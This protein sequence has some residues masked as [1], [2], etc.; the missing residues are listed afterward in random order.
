M[1]IAKYTNLR[2]AFLF[3]SLARGSYWQPV[4]SRFVKKFPNTV[5][6]TGLWEGFLSHYQNAFT[7]KVV[8]KTSFCKLPFQQQGHYPIGFV[9]APILKLIRELW[10]FK[11]HVLFV[12]GFSLWTLVAFIYKKGY[13]G[14]VIVIYDGSS[15]SVDRRDSKI[16]TLWRKYIS[17]KV[18]VFITNTKAGKKYLVTYL[19]IDQNKVLVH[20]Y[21][22]PDVSIWKSQISK[23]KE[24]QDRIIS[25][26]TVG[27]L[28]KQ[29]GIRELINATKILVDHFQE[30]RWYLNIVGDGPLRYEIE[31]MIRDYN[32]ENRIRLIGHVN[33]ELLGEVLNTQDVFIFPTFEDVWGVAPLEAM[34]LGKPVLC[35]KYAGAHE[36]ITEGKDGWI[37]DPHNPK[38]LAELMRKFINNPE[39][40]YIMSANAKRKMSKY[41]PEVAVNF[42]EQVMNQVIE[43]KDDKNKIDSIA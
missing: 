22:V 25:F 21:E 4:L 38:E 6:F 12:S 42:L 20:P 24:N 3:P 18:D 23:R 1:T 10:H 11:P 31:R 39:L 41:T 8:G 14:K 36:L 17:R 15:P 26:V 37:F 33:Y 40:I 28:I 27:R 7:V 16:F 13:R 34:A 19:K 35:S 43:R 5:V 29:K 32:L 9:R 2:V 30:D